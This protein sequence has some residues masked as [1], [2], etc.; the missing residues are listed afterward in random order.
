[1]DSIVV[2]ASAESIHA[3]RVAHDL[4]L[5]VEAFDGDSNAAGLTV[6]DHAQVVDITRPETVIRSLSEPPGVI[7]PVPIG[8][9]LTSTGALNDYYGLPGVTEQA[10]INCTDKYL[11][12]QIMTQSGLRSSPS[13]LVPAGA[14]SFVSPISFPVVLK[15]RYGSGS[16]AVSICETAGDLDQAL[17][18]L[19]PSA[20]DFLLEE[21]VEGA[22]YGLD[23][24]VI[25]GEFQMI[26]LREKINTPPP[27]RQAVGYYSVVQGE[28][29]ELQRAAQEMMSRAVAALGLAN[30]L[31]H[32][33]LLWD[34]RGLFVIEV[35]ARPSGH[36]L[37]DLFTPACTGIDPVKE[38]VKFAM[39]SLRQPFL[40]TPGHVRH[41]LI[42]FFDFANCTVVGAPAPAR[43][44]S[45]FHLFAYEEHCLG[46]HMD[47]VSN[48][49]ELMKRGFF[50][51]EGTS[52]SELEEGSARLLSLFS[53]KGD[54]NEPV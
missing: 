23:A 38:F 10:A 37:H 17:R 31:L 26:L 22:E 43:L 14:A 27:F 36:H 53:L 35:S 24:A 1:M 9:Y 11:F 13:I 2:G 30:C 6:A 49:P 15:P 19:L 32:A 33:D 12:S 51:L 16:R 34:G 25:D 18:V 20:E 48:G 3:I 5:Q 52:R 7:L 42:R 29:V 44:Q 28:Q 4:G 45:E 21:Y 41:M 50:V 40:F 54:K 8:R 39:P 46:L 47:P